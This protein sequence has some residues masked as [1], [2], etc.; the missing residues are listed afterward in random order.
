[1]VALEFKL[2]KSDFRVLPL[3]NCSKA[4]NHWKKKNKTFHR[5]VSEEGGF[6]GR[7]DLGLKG[8]V[9]RSRNSEAQVNSQQPT[10]SWP[11][12]TD[13]SKVAILHIYTHTNHTCIMDFFFRATPWH[14]KVR[15]IRAAAASVLHS[16]SNAISKPHLWPTPWLMA[17]PDP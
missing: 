2:R 1:M 10:G 12:F 15:Q 11:Q 13:I 8:S 9:L 7:L 6:V 3:N 16:H 5:F 17:M 4:R 14:M